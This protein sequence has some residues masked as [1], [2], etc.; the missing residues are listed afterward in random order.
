MK[1][2]VVTGIHKKRLLD[3]LASKKKPNQRLRKAM[4]M[5]KSANQKESKNGR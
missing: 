3:I 5:A 2:I 1:T 4:E